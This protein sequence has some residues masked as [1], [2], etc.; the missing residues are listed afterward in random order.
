MEPTSILAALIAPHWDGKDPATV[1]KPPFETDLNSVLTLRTPVAEPEPGVAAETDHLR[2]LLAS[3]GGRD[4][5]GALTL[6]VWSRGS[7]V[8]SQLDSYT[9]SGTSRLD[10]LYVLEFQGSEQMI[11]FGHS[12]NLRR[13]VAVHRQN[14]EMFGFALLNGW[15]SPGV[16][17]ASYAEQMGKAAVY[18]LRGHI[19]SRECVY[20]MPFREALSIARAAFEL[21]TDWRPHPAEDALVR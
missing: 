14:A 2:D 20:N 18:L 12:T 4:Q 5:T 8:G 13:R 3:G 9:A 1:P 11:K 17:D 15:A 6:E 10:R 21:H 19:L 7:A 16:D